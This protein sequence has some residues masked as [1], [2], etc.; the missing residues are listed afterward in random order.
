MDSRSHPVQ[1]ETEMKRRN[2]EIVLFAVP[3]SGPAQDGSA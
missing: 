2:I 1:G 3:L